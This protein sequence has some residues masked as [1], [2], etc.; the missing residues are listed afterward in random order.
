MDQLTPTEEKVRQFIVKNLMLKTSGS[1]LAVEQPLLESGIMTSFG[2]V[3]MVSYLE[4]NFGVTIDDYDVVPENFQTVRSI[5]HLV[6][7]KQKK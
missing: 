1:T 5:A 3:E 6:E 4:Q 7:Q 2:I